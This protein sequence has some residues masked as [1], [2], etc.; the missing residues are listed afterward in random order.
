MVRESSP[1][2]G[3]IFHTC[4]W[5]PPSLLYKEYRVFPGGGVKRPERGVEHPTTSRA[6]VKENVEVYLYSPFGPS[7]PVTG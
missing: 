7:W 3:E 2:G 1:R 6:E 5:G 4:P